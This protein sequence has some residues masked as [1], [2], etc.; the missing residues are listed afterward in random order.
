VD[1][2][3]LKNLEVE[4]VI[5]IWEWEKRL[6]QKVVFDL[7]LSTDIKVAADS[8]SI[9][10]ALDYKAVAK[11]IKAIVADHQFE[12]IETLAETIAQTILNEF[13]VSWLKLKVSKP[14][15]IRDSENVGLIIER[16]KQEA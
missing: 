13:D 11:R 3:F 2:I 12:L 14:F 6:P 16:T 10:D 8:D 1:K 4:T 7:E 5:G 15:A 9:D